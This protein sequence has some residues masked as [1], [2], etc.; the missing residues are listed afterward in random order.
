MNSEWI[1]IFCECP[2][3]PII[4]QS[5][6]LMNSFAIPHHLTL[7][8][9]NYYPG[10]LFSKG[11][12]WSSHVS[13]PY[14]IRVRDRTEDSS[15]ARSRRDTLPLLMVFQVSAG[16]TSMMK[17]LS[18]SSPLM[19]LS[20]S[21]TQSHIHK[22]VTR[23]KLSVRKFTLTFMLLG[24]RGNQERSSEVQTIPISS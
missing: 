8:E 17:E 22:Y 24:E 21:L 20:L 2:R 16:G 9:D 7:I 12:S 19:Q 3:N 5:I 18:K 23:L 11:S 4:T 13:S 14:C 15:L 1:R 6:A 10:W